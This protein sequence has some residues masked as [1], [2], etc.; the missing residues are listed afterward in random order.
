MNYL[1]LT[2]NALIQLENPALFIQ[3][4][5]AD[6]D[7]TPRP[8]GKA[9]IRGPK[10]GRLIRTLADVR[11]PYGVRALAEA[12]SLAPGYISRLLD[13]LD[14]DAI[15]ERTKR[16][17]VE[18]VEIAALLR[19]WAESYDVFDSNDATLFLAPQG[20]A[21][22]LSAL[23]ELGGSAELAVTGSF[24]A[25]RYAPVAA[26]ALL[27]VYSDSPSDLAA[28]LRMIPADTGANVAV[29]RPFDPVV[30]TRTVEADRIRF[31]APSQTVVDCL[32]GNGRMPSEGEALLEWMLTNESEWRLDALPEIG[33]TGD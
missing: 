24:S 17:G 28:A 31:V 1:D 20:A 9:R 15:V 5:G 8:R 11:P 33:R 6:R 18:D 12:T 25:V 4:R 32:T 23:T 16:G 22:A 14:D 19:R 2:E 21:Q 30:W 7:P 27:T 13:A 3:S 29:L 10:A 26:P